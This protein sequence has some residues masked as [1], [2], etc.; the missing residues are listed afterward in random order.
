MQKELDLVVY[1]SLNMD[2]VGYVEKLPKPGETL[3]SN[4]F[5]VSPGGK[6]ANQAVASA[7]LG[8]KTAMIG[9][10]G[11]DQI[12]LSM[13]E[14]L[15]KAHVDNECV[16]ITEDVQTGIA[17]VW[18]NEAGGNSIVTY[19]GA[20]ENLTKDDIDKSVEKVTRSQGAI[21]QLEMPKDVAQYT[22][23][24]VSKQGKKVILNL[25]PIV[26]I[27]NHYMKMIDL[28]IVNEPEAE[29]LA[30]NKVDSIESAKEAIHI[31]SELGIE[32]I[33]IT[34]GEQGAVFKSGN[35]IKH[36]AAPKVEAIDTTGAGDCFV[37]AVS[38]F[39]LRRNNLDEA[40]KHA[41]QVAALAVTKKGAINS[42]PTIKDY[43]NF[44]K[45]INI[46]I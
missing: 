12:G 2:Y 30:G 23:E 13:K 14:E 41:I 8:A 26:D 15:S 25:A 32:H 11:N 31:I 24:T 20:N 36:H 10:V 40:V 39:W 33:I 46:D 42:L 16:T 45:Q 1:G 21:L 38:Y 29:F 3:A 18:V 5:I 44:Q 28:L 7:K 17:M 4:E 35:V 9:R 37:G 22:I 34:L 6:A 43:E 27:E 19:K